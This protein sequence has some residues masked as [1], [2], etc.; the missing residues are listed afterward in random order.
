MS[1]YQH[2]NNS[3]NQ[4]NKKQTIVPNESMILISKSNCLKVDFYQ[5]FWWKMDINGKQKD[6]SSKYVNIME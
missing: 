1:K 6:V 5:G 2:I 4:K 3:V